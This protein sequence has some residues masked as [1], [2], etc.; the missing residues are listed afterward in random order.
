MFIRIATVYTFSVAG[1][2]SRQENL[3]VDV[4]IFRIYK[5]KIYFYFGIKCKNFKYILNEN[6]WIILFCSS[7]NLSL[8]LDISCSNR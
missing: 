8:N 7:T 6:R 1:I 3:E 2:N 5:I 4:L